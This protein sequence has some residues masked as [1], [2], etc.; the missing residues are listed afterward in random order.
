MSG[1]RDGGLDGLGA[2]L[3]PET[4]EVP[5]D[6]PDV[7]CEPLRGPRVVEGDGLSHVDDDDLPVPDEEVV[8]AEVRVDEPRLPDRAEVPEDVLVDGRGVLDLHVLE[9]GSGPLLIPHVLHDED[10]LLEGFVPRLTFLNRASP[11]MYRA[12]FR[13][14]AVLIR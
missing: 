3:D 4:A 9:E 10:V 12:R 6:V 11:S 5:R 2:R 14:V 8:L 1:P 13:N 7:P